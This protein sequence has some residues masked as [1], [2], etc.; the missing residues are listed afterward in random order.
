MV[1]LGFF[2]FF[3]FLVSVSMHFFYSISAWILFEVL[4]NYAIYVVFSE[5]DLLQSRLLRWFCMLLNDL[6]CSKMNF[7]LCF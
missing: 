1:L 4:F 2:F 3:Y 7:W 6:F 5:M